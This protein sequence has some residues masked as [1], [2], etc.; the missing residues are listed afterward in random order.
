MIKSRLAVCVV[1]LIFFFTLTTAQ[2]VSAASDYCEFTLTETETLK[3]CIFG[4]NLECKSDSRIAAFVVNLNFDAD[5]LEFRNAQTTDDLAYCRVNSSE[6]GSVKVVYLCEDGIDCSSA[7]ALVDFTFKALKSADA[8]INLDVTQVIDVS[9]QDVEVDSLRGGNVSVTQKSTSPKKTD[10]DKNTSE[11]VLEE[12][13]EAENE[14]SD[15]IKTDF[16]KGKDKDQTLIA[17][18]VLSAAT[19][20]IIIGFC[21]YKIGVAVAYKRKEKALPHDFQVGECPNDKTES[22][23]QNEEKS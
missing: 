12:T 11:A 4:V 16:V 13:T 6:S 21:A 9:A 1:L 2:M 14:Q 22:R 15:N 5:L 18:V 7:K 23:G 8:T 17:T 10:K 3:G 19:L 20:I